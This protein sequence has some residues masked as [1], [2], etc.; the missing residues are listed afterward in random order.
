LNEVIALYR[1]LQ[2]HLSV[3]ILGEGPTD[4]TSVQKVEHLEELDST[5]ESGFRGVNTSSP[6]SI[7]P[8]WD[9]DIQLMGVFLLHERTP[10][11]LH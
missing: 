1:S 11:Q 6:F 3:E 2:D 4:E 10:S 7:T 9:C 8:M 5:S